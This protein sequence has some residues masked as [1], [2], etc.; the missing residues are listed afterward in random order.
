M[1]HVV[2]IVHVP[3]IRQ[4]SVFLQRMPWVMSTGE[5]CW[6]TKL[7]VCRFLQC[8]RVVCLQSLF[9]CTVVHANPRKG[10]RRLPC[11]NAFSRLCCHHA[12]ARLHSRGPSTSPC[13]APR[14]FGFGKSLPVQQRTSSA[15]CFGR[16]RDAASRTACHRSSQSSFSRRQ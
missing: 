13:S 14:S 2:T 5:L 10:A 15:V 3:L 8:G 11:G 9:L 4:P 12:K 1:T 7:E 6:A 16:N